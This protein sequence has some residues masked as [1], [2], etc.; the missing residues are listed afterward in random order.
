MQ[1]FVGGLFGFLLELFLVLLQRA[2]A[3]CTS[4]GPQYPCHVDPWG[5]FGWFFYFGE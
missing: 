3:P 2:A 4:A 5:G 1:E